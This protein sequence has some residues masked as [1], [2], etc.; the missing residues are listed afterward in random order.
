MFK[1]TKWNCIEGKEES[2]FVLDIKRTSIFLLIICCRDSNLLHRE[3]MLSC[4]KISL[5]MFLRCIFSKALRG[6]R[7]ALLLRFD[8]ISRG[9]LK[10]WFSRTDLCPELRKESD[11]LTSSWML[12]SGIELLT[13]KIVGL[14]SL[15]KAILP[16]LLVLYQSYCNKNS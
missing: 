16:L 1:A 6:S 10:I 4:A 8:G 5:L 13:P 9:S 2:I 3:F 15:P 11:W 14:F 12:C 7:E